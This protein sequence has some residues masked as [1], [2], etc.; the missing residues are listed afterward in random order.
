[1][2]NTRMS[3]STCLL[4]TRIGLQMEQTLFTWSVAWMRAKNTVERINQ[5]LARLQD[6]FVHRKRHVHCTRRK[7]TFSERVLVILE[8][9]EIAS[10]RWKLCL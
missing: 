3:V 1:M 8:F 6:V 4:P 5:P 7:L 2:L 10:S 9:Q